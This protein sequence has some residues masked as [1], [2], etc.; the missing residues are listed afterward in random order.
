MANSELYNKTFRVPS[1]VLKHIQSTLVS[2]PTGEGVKR[3]KN[4][5]KSGVITYQGMKRLKN[6][7][8]YFKPNED[9]SIQYELAGGKLMKSFI[10]RTLNTE[11]DAV[12]RGDDIKS[13]FSINPNLGIKAQQSPRLNEEEK[14]E[15]LK[16]N[17][18]GIIVNGDKKIL[19]LKRSDYPDQWMPNKWSLVGGAIE[20]GETPEKACKRE[21]EEETS[22]VI[23]KL[24]NSFAIQRHNDSIEHVF[25]VKFN[26]EPTDINLND[27]NV[28]YGWYSVPE[29]NYLDTVPHLVEYITLAFKK[30]E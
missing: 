30:Y 17:V 14:K 10:E 21:I 2:N 4:I 24:S 18:V 5:L 28:S 19:L 15:E 13:S 22:L 1:D 3:A 25:L 6:F 12:K 7:F 26:G 11:R 23:D 27:E 20:K 29:M 9:S 8:D 16:K